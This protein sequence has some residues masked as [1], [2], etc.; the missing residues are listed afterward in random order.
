MSAAPNYTG[1][2]T[3]QFKA[4]GQAGEKMIVQLIDGCYSC[5]SITVLGQDTLTF[6]SPD[7][8]DFGDFELS[9]GI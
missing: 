7:S 3:V 8:T 5:G 4:D 1:P 6:A 9:G 2:Y